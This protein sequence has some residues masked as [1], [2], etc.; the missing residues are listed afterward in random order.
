MAEKYTPNY[1]T[2][3][4]RCTT[5]YDLQEVL[6]KRLHLMEDWTRMYLRVFVEEGGEVGF[7]SLLVLV[8]MRLCVA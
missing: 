2:A 3:L 6:Q 7:S 5:I 4:V 1:F 8:F